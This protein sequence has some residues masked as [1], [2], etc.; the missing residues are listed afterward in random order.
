MLCLNEGKTAC[1]PLEEGVDFLGYHFG[2]TGMAIPAKAERNL[3]ERLETMWLTSSE[4][5]VEEKLKNALEIVGGWEQYFRGERKVHSIFEYIV[6]MRFSGKKKEGLENQRRELSNYC[7]DIAV[8]LAKI[9]KEEGEEALELLEYE[10]FYQI[11]TLQGSGQKAHDNLKEL[12][13]LYRS[14][15]IQENADTAG[16]YAA[17][18]R[19]RG[20]PK[21]RILAE[22]EGTSGEK[23][24]WHRQSCDTAGQR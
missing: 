24:I 17:I 10:Q 2:S 9:W 7:K 14:Y 3:E 13:D 16:A 22:A 1:V 12:L 6:L 18:F 5:T 21:G 23:G 20:V 4:K 8:Y 15:I 11:W 19:Q